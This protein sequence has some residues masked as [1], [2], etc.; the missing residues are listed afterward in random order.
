MLLYHR[1]V[2]CP[3]FDPGTSRLSSECSPKWANRAKLAGPDRFELPTAGF[4]DQ[5]SSAELR[6]VVWCCL[7]GSNHVPRF[8]RPVLWPHQLKQHCLVLKE[9]IELSIHSY[10][11]CVI[12]F[13]YKSMGWS[14]E[15]NPVKLIHSQL[16]N[17]YISNTI[18]WQRV[19]GSNQW[20][21]SQS[22]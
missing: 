19:L 12:P 1:L 17:H 3:G 4:E 10:Q 5:N 21:Q 6:T 22:L 16:C 15:S 14:R 2:P 13:N 20:W 8:F 11:E 18:D 7:V 9:R